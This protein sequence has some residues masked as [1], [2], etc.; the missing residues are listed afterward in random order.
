[1]RESALE[2][3]TIG[4]I[5]NEAREGILATIRTVCCGSLIRVTELRSREETRG[6]ERDLDAWKIREIDVRRTLLTDC[7]NVEFWGK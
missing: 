2:R 3:A 7:M 6:R 1:M 4:M 5:A